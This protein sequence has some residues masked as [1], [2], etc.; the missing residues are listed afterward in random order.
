[1][2]EGHEHLAKPGEQVDEAE[3]RKAMLDDLDSRLADW[4][5]HWS[6]LDE[7][8]TVAEGVFVSDWVFIAEFESA[9]GTYY[10]S[11]RFPAH[12]RPHRADGLLYSALHGAMRDTE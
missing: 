12:T 4:A 7:D 1:M 6:V 5:N 11:K 10:L 3:R 2:D 9:D 8:G